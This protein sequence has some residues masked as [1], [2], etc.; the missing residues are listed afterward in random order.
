MRR[1]GW[2]SAAADAATG[3]GRS[4]AEKGP[5]GT[6]VATVVA[7]AV[8]GR[9]AEEG[10]VRAAQPR[11]IQDSPEGF[12]PDVAAADV[13]VTIDVRGEGS[14]G[15]VHMDDADVIEAEGG[16]CFIE[17]ARQA[18]GRADVEAGGEEMRGVE[19][20]AGS[21]DDAAGAAAIEHLPQM[22]ELRAEAS[23]LPCG[24]FDEDA[25]GGGRGGTEGR[26]DAGATGGAGDGCCDV[27]DAAGDSGITS[28]AGM[29]DQEVGAELEG[30]DDLVAKGH[31]GI[32]P[33]ARIGRGEIDQIVGVD[34]DGTEA[35]L[36]AALA[37]T[38]CNGSGDGAL[39]RARPHAGAAGENLQR[40]AADARGSVQS[41]AG[42]TGD[43]GVDADARAA[44]EPRRGGNYSGGGLDVWRFPGGL[45][46]NA[47]MRWRL[48][49]GPGYTWI[50]LDLGHSP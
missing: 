42:L 18:F 49:D 14:L 31:D 7:W 33:Q 2:R 21:G 12:A 19:T 35:E 46:Q 3:P 4:E 23:S 45:G 48:L 41:A 29:N 37:E 13:L 10:A 32:F 40:G 1:R 34:G 28:G 15:V 6:D 22:S 43:G 9:F 8:D 11:M 50:G 27:L 30:A 44:V 36:S 39:M 16:V 24:V 20:D 26:R 47:R 25:E 5:E 38:L 17:G